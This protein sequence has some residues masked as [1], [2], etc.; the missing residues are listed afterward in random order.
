MP[1]AQPPEGEDEERRGVLDDERHADRDALDRLVVDELDRE[2]PEQA[3]DHKERE[4]R[5]TDRCEVASLERERDREEHDE[6]E[7]DPPLR[8][9]LRRDAEV[10]GSDRD[11]AT[12][13]VERGGGDREQVAEGRTAQSDSQSRG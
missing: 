11:D 9:G 1:A 3:E 10:E 5:A 6:R 12:D 8:Q 4:V 13:R 2:D 7:E